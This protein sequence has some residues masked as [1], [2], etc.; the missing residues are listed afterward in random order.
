M[1]PTIT[2]SSC[3]KIKCD[4]W[5]KDPKSDRIF[6]TCVYCRMRKSRH[7]L[8]IKDKIIEEDVKVE[9]NQ[10]SLIVTTK[11]RKYPSDT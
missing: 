9:E 3:R 7:T 1:N 8:I 2:C 10:D 4:S 5:F 6:K 11:N